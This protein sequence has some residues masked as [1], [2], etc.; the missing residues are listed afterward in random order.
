MAAAGK[1]TKCAP[2]QMKV[3][4]M[5][6][7]NTT[8][9]DELTKAK[10]AV[11]KSWM[12]IIIIYTLMKPRWSWAVPHANL[13]IAEVAKATIPITVRNAS[14]LNWLLPKFLS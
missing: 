5:R 7:V 4:I 13:D 2:S 8:F 1:M 6:K 3:K 10:V 11:V 14:S 9:E 12:T